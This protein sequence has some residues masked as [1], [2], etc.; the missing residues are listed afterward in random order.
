[1][2][3]SPVEMG[4]IMGQQAS[5]KPCM[6]VRL[7]RDRSLYYQFARDLFESNLVDFGTEAIETL[8]PFFVR[9]KSGKQRL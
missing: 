2:L 3:R 7:K 5:I 8:H 6:D 4:A 1:M 9:K